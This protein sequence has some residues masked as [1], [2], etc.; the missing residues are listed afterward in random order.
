M[1]KICLVN[2]RKMLKTV[3]K[4]YFFNFSLD[5]KKIEDEKL[6]N[7]NLTKEKLNSY[8]IK[9]VKNLLSN[10]QKLSQLELIYVLKKLKRQEEDYPFI[11][12]ERELENFLNKENIEESKLEKLEIKNCLENEE[13]KNMLNFNFGGSGGGTGESKEIEQEEVEE[14]TSFDVSVSSIDAKKKLKIIKEIKA[15]L[16]IGLKDAKDLVEKPPFKIKEGAGKEESEELKIKFEKIG[17][18]VEIK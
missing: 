12:I 13:I 4:R 17:C 9:K 18:I 2:F 14:Q 5:S 6:N 10:V 11:K 1:K 3:K 15:F 8:Q 16:G 7:L